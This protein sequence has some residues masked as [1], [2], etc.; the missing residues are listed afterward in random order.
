ML[1]AR[2]T[3]WLSREHRAAVDAELAPQLERLGDRTVE[4]EAKRIGYR[5]DPHGYVARVRA[6]AADRR[7]SIRPAP[8]AMVR[9]SALLPVAAGVSAYATLCRDA[10]L[11]LSGGDR[12]GRGQLMADLL[13]ERVT[14]Q[15]RADQ[16]P[17]EINLIMTDQALF[18]TG[19]ARN[20]PALLPGYG[21]LPA[22]LARHLA[23]HDEH[24]PRWIRRLY[25]RPSDGQLVALESR[26]RLFTTG[27]RR[28]LQLRDQTCR[29]PWCDAPIRHTD[30]VL[31]H[32]AGGRTTTSNGQG[33][34]AACNHA[35]QA[36][37]WNANT[38][39][40]ATTIELRTPTGHT[41]QSRAPDLPTVNRSKLR[42]RPITVDLVFAA[43]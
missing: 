16:V 31:P 8:D 18:N 28:F 42:H 36:P 4:A 33:L 22:P 1:L 30:H 20:E 12:R 7:V 35:K 27:Q 32:Q 23:T 24:V 11:N 19:P 2:E 38:P 25:T 6:V 10:D 26:R 39:D 17:V 29:T 37:G 21:P 14:G 15:T 9:L 40:G 13:V 41:Y 34:C 3:A 43:A 5:L